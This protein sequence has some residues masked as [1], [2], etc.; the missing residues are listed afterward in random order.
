MQNINNNTDLANID[1]INGV[2]NNALHTINTNQFWGGALHIRNTIS[3]DNNAIA[4]P[5]VSE[6]T[7]WEEDWS[8]SGGR[9][10]H[11]AP[12]APNA[13]AGGNVIARGMFVGQKIHTFLHD[14][15]TVTAEKSK[16]KFQS[17]VQDNNPVGQFY[18][19]LKRMI[20]L[21]YPLLLAIN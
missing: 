20:K 10:T 17:L 15:P 8:I 3:A 6:H 9:P 21:A 13:N 5:L 18:T 4:N 11:L 19:N 16:V 12:N 2:N 1:A 14:F 7:V